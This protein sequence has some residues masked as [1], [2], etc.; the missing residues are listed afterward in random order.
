MTIKEKKEVIKVINKKIKNLKKT[1]G[2]I[3]VRAYAL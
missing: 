3:G 2:K 1:K